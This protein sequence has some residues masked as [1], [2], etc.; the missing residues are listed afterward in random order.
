LEDLPSYY[1]HTLYKEYLLLQLDEKARKAAA[2]AE[3]TEDIIDEM[4]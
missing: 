2:E 4:T 3:A 1:L